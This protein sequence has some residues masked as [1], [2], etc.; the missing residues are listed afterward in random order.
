MTRGERQDVRVVPTWL[1]VVFGAG[2]YGDAVGWFVFAGQPY[3]QAADRLLTG[4]RLGDVRAG[5]PTDQDADRS[6]SNRG[7][8][9]ART[10]QSGRHS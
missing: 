10:G 8:R 5:Q 7:D 1:F 2:R 3:D 9:S 4:I 6:V